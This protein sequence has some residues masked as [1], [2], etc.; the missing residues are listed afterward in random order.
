MNIHAHDPNTCYCCNKLGR[1]LA[2]LKEAV[3]WFYRYVRTPEPPLEEVLEFDEV[4]TNK[5][6]A[7]VI[8]KV[9]EEK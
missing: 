8:L 6:H 7:D 5:R 1:K 9:L 3:R 4:E 2:A